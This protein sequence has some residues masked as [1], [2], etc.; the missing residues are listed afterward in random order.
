M[1]RRRSIRLR[2]LVL[3]LVP[4]IALIGLYSVVLGLTV[5]QLSSLR[6]ATTVRQQITNPT[7][8]LQA[9]L[10]TERWLALRFLARYSDTRMQNA[11]VVQQDA[12][13]AA[14]TN[15][16][17]AAAA[18]L[19][20]ANA[21][22]RRAI[23]AFQADLNKLGAI[24]GSVGGLGLTRAT[25][26][27]EYSSLIADGDAVLSQVIAPFS[28]SVGSQASDLIALDT[29][30]Q[31]LGEESDL[32]KA[33]LIAK[34]FSADDVALIGQLATQ[35][36]QSYNA[37]VPSLDPQYRAYL[38]TMIPR[39]AAQD[40]LFY[41]AEITSSLTDRVSLAAW[42]AKEGAYSAGFGAA[43]AKA[44]ARIQAA[45]QSQAHA[46]FVRLVLSGALGL[47]AIL[48]TI[49]V[50]IAVGRTLLRQLNDLRQSALELAS[51]SLPN[52]IERLRSGEDV[53]ADEAAAPLLEPGA[54][55]IGQ[56]RHAF[57]TAAQT[58]VAA[59]VEEIKIRRGVNDVFRNLAR[60]NQSLLTRQLQLLDAMERRVH[61]PEELADLFKIDHLTTRMRRHAE[62][63]LIVAGG[64]SGRVWRDP[65][66]VVDVM[67]AAI[68]EVENYTRIRV[69]SR[70]TAALAGHAVAD[71]IHLLAELV[72][73]A[74]MF[75]PA[76]TPVRIEGDVVAKGLALEIEDR[77]L[78]QTEERLA[79]FN[80]TLADPPLFELSGGDQLG[81]FIAG[82]LAKRH[83]IKITLRTSPYGGVTAVVLV[84]RSLVVEDVEAAP[85]SVSVRELGGRPMPELTGPQPDAELTAEVDVPPDPDAARVDTTSPA[86]AEAAG[87]TPGAAAADLDAAAVWTPSGRRAEVTRTASAAASSA[88]FEPPMAAM[89]PPFVAP[90]R[91][92]GDLP[93]RMPRSAVPPWAAAP[94]STDPDEAV[95]GYPIELGDPDDLPVRVR[96]ANLAPQLRDRVDA[97]GRDDGQDRP[98]AAEEASPEVSRNTMAAWQ[99][100]WERGR[101]V[102]GEVV[103]EARE[104]EGE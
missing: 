63:L 33:D 25:A 38:A 74:T 99:R 8:A 98:S 102:A 12:T 5:G 7:T 65:V 41:E 27:G 11:W 79:E 14:V 22:E 64:S 89:A 66:P 78:G 19:P 96:Q 34:S 104:E 92:A 67:R 70:T 1:L 88:G 84:P 15:F 43:L 28:S 56:V 77:G 6:Q 21:A 80:A 60:R 16:N 26:A 10:A 30:L 2:I 73:N 3:V 13:T 45:V 32:I 94:P 49:I 61:D 4:V 29:S 42:T 18:A 101:E 81:L 72:E 50:A 17:A 47:L 35:R 97:D 75:S 57:N 82:Q 23:L 85:G 100:G 76:N 90:V 36:Q 58:A 86:F 55:E 69:V 51:S 48:I 93:T 54:D 103:D 9:Q 20:S 39:A 52:T 83:D 59:A 87:A 46:T 68:A 37:A 71:V 44:S 31:D 40:V 53:S 24:R 62:G 95:I 91:A